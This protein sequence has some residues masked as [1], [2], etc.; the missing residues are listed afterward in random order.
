MVI[1]Q[2][3][4]TPML[5]RGAEMDGGI[6]HVFSLF[7]TPAPEGAPRFGPRRESRWQLRVGLRLWAFHRQRNWPGPVQSYDSRQGAA[8]ADPALR[9]AP[10]RLTELRLPHCPNVEP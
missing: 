10:F 2:W 3:S 9:H 4:R 8:P 6:R 1:R 5:K 7:G